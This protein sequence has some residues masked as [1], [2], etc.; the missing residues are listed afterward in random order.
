MKRKADEMLG[1]ELDE[2]DSSSDVEGFVIVDTP[3][4]HRHRPAAATSRR[5][6]RRSGLPRHSVDSQT[7]RSSGNTNRN[8]AG[9]SR[10]PFSSKYSTDAEVLPIDYVDL[11]A[12]PT[13]PIGTTSRHARQPAAARTNVKMSLGKTTAP[14]RSS[15]S[16][17][18][19]KA[20]SNYPSNTP[21]QSRLA[22][23][24]EVTVEKLAEQTAVSLLRQ[25]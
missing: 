8:A 22:G 9:M 23:E 1:D 11:T 16:P 25:S 18:R 5:S 4:N 12:K 10:P 19:S 15:P 13:L 20:T 3:T 14:R 24:S 17:R 2:L 7:L 21:G 6:T